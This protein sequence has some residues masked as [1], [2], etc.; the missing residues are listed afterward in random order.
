MACSLIRGRV[1][2]G[3]HLYVGRDEWVFMPHKRNLS[4]H[5][6]PIRWER[7]EG[8]S[9]STEPVRSRWLRVV[10][11]GNLPDRLVVSLGG[12][13]DELVVPDAQL[14]LTELRLSGARGA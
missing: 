11:G 5:L 4:G 13:R 1:A 2:V 7:P 14:A 9:L 8:L 6:N 3:G 12:L 10:L